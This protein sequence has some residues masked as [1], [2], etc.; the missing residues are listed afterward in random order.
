MVTYCCCESMT[1]TD[2]SKSKMDV[3]FFELLMLNRV[4]ALDAG[5]EAVE[6]TARLES[7]LVH[8]RNLVEFLECRQESKQGS[9]KYLKASDFKTK[10]GKQVDKIEV[11]LC[12]LAYGALSQSLAH[13][14]QERRLET[15]MVWHCGTIWRRVNKAFAKFLEQVPDDQY[16][17]TAEGHTRDEFEAELAKAPTPDK[18]PSESLFLTSG[19][20]STTRDQSAP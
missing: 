19:G 13:I 16:F 7:F 15:K 5:S 17:P 2:V 6:R 14:P 4:L 11:G 18:Y 8:V 12:G 20:F 10:S 9:K 1:L 3:L